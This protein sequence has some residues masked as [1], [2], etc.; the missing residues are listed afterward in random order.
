MNRKK[1]GILLLC[2]IGLTLSAL[3]IRASSKKDVPRPPSSSQEPI[4][5]SQALSQPYF[6]LGGGGQCDAYLSQDDQFVLKFM[7]KKSLSLPVWTTHLPLLKQWIRHRNHGKIDE[8]K[9]KLINAFELCFQK[10]ARETGLLYLHF[11]PTQDLN[12]PIC[13][14]D[15]KGNSRF[16]DLNQEQFVLQKKA[17]LA[18]TTLETLMKEGDLQGAMCAIDKLLQLHVTLHEKGLRNRDPNFRSNCGFIGLEPVLIDVGRVVEE[19]EEK[20]FLKIAPR[21]RRYLT[22]FYPQ[23]LPHFDASVEKITAANNL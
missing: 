4:V 21:L 7:K 6:Y 5:L 1:T 20:D 23:L 8:R 3:G 13:L 22:T 15:S 17:T 12:A 2:L 10:A 14:T 11:T 18:T 9:N 19:K 16:V